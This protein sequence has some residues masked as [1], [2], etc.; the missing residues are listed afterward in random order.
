MCF[1]GSACSSASPPYNQRVRGRS[2]GYVQQHRWSKAIVVVAGHSLK[3]NNIP[4]FTVVSM[5]KTD[6]VRHPSFRYVKRK[7]ALIRH[8][9]CNRN[10]LFLESKTRRAVLWLSP[11]V[12][13]S[14]RQKTVHWW[15][16]R[17]LTLVGLSRVKAHQT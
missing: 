16:S 11:R 9:K 4:N 14:V 13:N 10:L 12:S 3:N 2:Q 5:T 6:L 1:P 8:N 7:Y 17:Q 15:I